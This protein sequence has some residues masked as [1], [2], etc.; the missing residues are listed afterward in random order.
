MLYWF[1]IGVA[2]ST[3]LVMCAGCITK[4]PTLYLDSGPVIPDIPQ[5]KVERGWNPMDEDG[6]VWS[7]DAEDGTMIA[8]CSYTYMKVKGQ[9]RWRGVFFHQETDFQ[10][11]P[12]TA[13]KM[14]GL[15]ECVEW[16]ERFAM[17]GYYL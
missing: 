16:A 5:A 10:F 4:M 2:L 12:F 1:F 13:A 3:L 7:L 15:C 9:E 11:K 17:G 8:M 14:D 6:H